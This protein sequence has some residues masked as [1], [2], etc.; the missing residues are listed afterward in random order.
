MKVH[1][2][3]VLV[4]GTDDCKIELTVTKECK[5]KTCGETC[6]IE[7]TCCKKPMKLKK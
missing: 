5:S 7:A 4:C 6:N 2:G 1:E 3:D